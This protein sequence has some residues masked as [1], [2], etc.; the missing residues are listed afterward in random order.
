MTKQTFRLVHLEARKRAAQAVAEAPEGQVVTISEPSRNL[1]QNA[2]LWVYLTAFS[3]QL[4]WP[5]NGQMV[6]MDPDSW[7]EV[8]SAAYRKESARLAMGLDG[9]VVMLGMRTSQMGKREFAEFI[10]FI[11]S[12]AADRGV[13]LDEVKA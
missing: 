12:V 11:M 9:G 2:L 7:K 4:V 1:E 3:K 10:E 13:V 6:K 5:V 8:L